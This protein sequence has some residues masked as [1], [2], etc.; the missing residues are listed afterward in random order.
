ME[1]GIPRDLFTKR[2]KRISQQNESQ[3]FSEYLKSFPQII[4]KSR[5]ENYFDKNADNLSSKKKRDRR[6]KDMKDERNY[7]CGCGK[8]YLSYAALYTH[9]KTKH[10]GVFPDGTTNLQKKNNDI[11][12]KG[13]WNIDHINCEYEKTYR[14]NQS[15]REFIKRIEGRIYENSRH[16]DLIEEFPCEIFLNESYY[17]DILFNIEKIRLE[18]LKTYGS[19]FLKQI[20]II[21]LEINNTRNLNCN[22]IL[23]IFLIYIFRF[24]S[25]KLYKELIFLI[26]CYRDLLN[27]KGWEKYLEMNQEED[28]NTDEEFC[29]V[30]GAEI[31]PDFSNI[32]VMDYFFWYIEENNIVRNNKEFHFLGFDCEKLLNLMLIIENFCKW[33]HVHKFT[34]AT[35][36][37]YKD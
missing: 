3:D 25:T 27:K 20:D 15:F 7:I 19:N 1:N 12:S 21:I 17:K 14:F 18:M 10:E 2:L 34:S 8:S 4:N 29:E 28:I 23:A 31:I 22:Q 37:I 32:F 6:L 30:Q 16:Q 33:L 36:E 35:V 5:D 9:A 26:I 24:I 13:D 11:K